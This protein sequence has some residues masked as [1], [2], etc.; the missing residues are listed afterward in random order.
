LW[1]VAIFFSFFFPFSFFSYGLQLL[2]FSVD[3]FFVL[4]WV[5]SIVLLFLNAYLTGWQGNFFFTSSYIYILG[6]FYTILTNL[7]GSY[8]TLVSNVQVGLV[9]V[10]YIFR[11]FKELL[12]VY[13]HTW[14]PVFKRSGYAYLLNSSRARWNL[15]QS[16]NSFKNK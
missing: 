3:F 2:D 16:H 11:V 10:G 12:N 6:F 7:Q 15:S 13:P 9:Y 5:V 4:V 1:L 8:N 14:R